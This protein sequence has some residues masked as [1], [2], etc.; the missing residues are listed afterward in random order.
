LR[1][2]GYRRFYDCA[3]F[4]ALIRN[5]F[6]SEAIGCGNHDRVPAGRGLPSPSPDRRKINPDNVL[7]L[8]MPEDPA[9]L[10]AV[11]HFSATPT[12]RVIVSL[13]V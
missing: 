12:F 5:T 6:F 13:L 10:C 4:C 3:R 9:R 11:I 7:Y 2:F 1:T 8:E